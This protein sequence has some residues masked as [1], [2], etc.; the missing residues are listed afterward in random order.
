MFTAGLF[1]LKLSNVPETPA[2]LR[3]REVTRNNIALYYVL[4]WSLTKHQPQAKTWMDPKI[5]I[6]NSNTNL[7]ID[8]KLKHRLLTQTSATNSNMDFKLK[9]W[10]LTQAST[11]NSNINSEFKHRLLIQK[12]DYWLKHR[13]W[14]QTST[15][16]SN[17]DFDLKYWL[18]IQTST[19]NSNIEY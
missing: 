4:H 7:N 13:L 9:H 12:I 15:S 18:L 19:L 2:H 8:S 17:T 5:D 14:T 10:L 1:Q 6:A 3:M 11:S 16:N